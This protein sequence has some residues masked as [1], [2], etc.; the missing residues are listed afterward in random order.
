V[1]DWPLEPA[2]TP[3]QRNLYRVEEIANQLTG[4]ST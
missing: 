1:H 4:A 3:T 2:D